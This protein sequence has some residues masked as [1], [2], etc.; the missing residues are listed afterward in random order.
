M[1]LTTTD[2]AVIIGIVAAHQYVADSDTIGH[3]S[4]GDAPNVTSWQHVAHIIDKVLEV[5]G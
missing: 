2:V 3:C 5:Y 4:G 1:S